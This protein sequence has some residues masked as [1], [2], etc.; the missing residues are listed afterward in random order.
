M[1]LGK[2]QYAR[3]AILDRRQATQAG[4]AVVVAVLQGF[5]PDD[6][7]APTRCTDWSAHDVVRH[8]CDN[9][10]RA[11]SIGPDDRM[12][13]ITTGYDPR[14]TPRQWLSASPSRRCQSRRWDASRL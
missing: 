9:N 12:L 14:I 6:W 7:A 2:L 5:G 10:M 13:D 3:H 1:Q 8:L 11:A 4:L